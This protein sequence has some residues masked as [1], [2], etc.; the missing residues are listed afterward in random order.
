MPEF[1]IVVSTWRLID[2]YR[3][4]PKPVVVK[5]KITAPM[6]VSYK[7]VNGLRVCA[8]K[9]DKPGKSKQGKSKHM[10][11]ECCLDPDEY[12]NPHCYYDPAKYGKYLK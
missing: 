10:D 4:K 1:F 8:K 6:P 9:N 3:P 7:K 12:P 2:I 5:P 11:M